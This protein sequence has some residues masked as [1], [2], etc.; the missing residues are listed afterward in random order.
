M[1]NLMKYLMGSRGMSIYKKI[2]FFVSLLVVITLS[3]T[4]YAQVPQRPV[5]P[6][7]VNDIA[8]IFTPAE[9]NILESM[10]VTFS[11]ST[12][13]QITVVVV[14]ELYGM[15]KAE[16]AYQIGEQ[17]KVGQKSF[18]NGIVILIKPKTTDSKGEVF[19]ATG[20]GLEGVLTDAVCRRVIETDMIPYFRQDDYYN[21]VISALKTIMPIVSGE[22]SE[23]SGSN[24]DGVLASFLFLG[25][26]VAFV[27]I[28]ALLSKRKNGPT[29]MGGGGKNK[30]SALDLLLLG[31]IFMSSGRGYSGR[32]GGFGSGGGSFGGGGFGGF[33]GGS[34]GGGGAGGSW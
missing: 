23:R 7:L 12:S 17:W 34:F 21:A 4:L 31:S 15:D 25:F 22:I 32:S 19:I 1:N 16:L 10:L 3:S 30:I 6:R 2:L 8:G 13:N 18:D 5:P 14:P 26:I 24:G 11:D 20:Y 27:I 29:N 33:G 9:Q 28:I